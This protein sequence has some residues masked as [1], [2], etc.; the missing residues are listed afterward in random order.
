MKIKRTDKGYKIK[1]DELELGLISTALFDIIKMI[2]IENKEILKEMQ[3]IRLEMLREIQLTDEEATAEEIE[4]FIV[5]VAD[6][7]GIEYNRT[8]N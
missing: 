1:L 4:E 3:K 5:S 6:E 8:D 2:G 7:V